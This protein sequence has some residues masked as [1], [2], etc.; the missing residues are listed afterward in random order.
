MKAGY[1]TQFTFS[2]VEDDWGNRMSAQNRVA[3]KYVELTC[4]LLLDGTGG[5]LLEKPA[6]RDCVEY[7]L[8]VEVLEGGRFPRRRLV[9][10]A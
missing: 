5:G 8:C 4:R 6:L 10:S 9:C 1:I 3:T 2:S 7:V